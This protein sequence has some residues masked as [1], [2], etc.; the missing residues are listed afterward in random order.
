[1]SD[2]VI[3]PD[4]GLSAEAS[5]TAG[6][7]GVPGPRKPYRR[8]TVVRYGDVT[9]LTRSGAT[10]AKNDKGSGSKTRTD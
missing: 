3:R 4:A 2:D 10:G 1:M 6:R 5:A 7:D 9:T 8:P